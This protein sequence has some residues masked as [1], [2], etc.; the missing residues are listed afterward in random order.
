MSKVTGINTSKIQRK[1]PEWAK[2]DRVINGL[3]IYNMN[4][5]DNIMTFNQDNLDGEAIHYYGTSITYGE[6]PGLRDAYARGLAMAGVKEGDVVT[7]CMPVSI[8]NTMLLFAVNLLNAVSNNVNFLYLKH[9]FKTYTTDKNSHIVVTLD[10]F[11]PYFVDHLEEST[12]DTVIVMNLDDFLPEK[13]KGLFMDTSEM[14]KKMQE[15]FDIN[16]IMACLMNLDKIKGVNFIKLDELRKA[17]AESDIPLPYGPTN[18]DRDIS[19]YYTSGTTGKP[20]CVVY[21]EY[22]L[23]AYVEMHAGLDTQNVVGE[24]NFQ[25][26]PLTHMTGERVCTIMP[27]ARGGIL[28]PQPI[29]NNK[30]FARDLAASKCNCVVATAS[31][32]MKA[33]K[34]GVLGPDALKNLTRPGSGGEPITKSAVEKVDKWLRANGCNVRYSLG[35]GASEEGGATLVTYFMDEKTKTNETGLPLEPHVHVKLVDDEGNLI[36]EDEVLG[37]LHV[38]SPAAA[39][40]YLDNPEATAERWYVDEDGVKWGV[41]GDI[42]VRHADGSYNIL[43]R[44]SDSYINEKGERVYLFQIEYSLDREDPILEWEISAF[45]NECGGY[46]VVG[47]IILD[48]NCKTP[49]NELVDYFCKKYNLAAVKFY[50]EFELGEIT[51]KRDFVLLAHDYKGYVS[52]CDENHHY[53]VNYSEDGK[54]VRQKVAIIHYQY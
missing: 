9:D 24:R 15:V 10:A 14:P 51:N 8:E 21:K 19:Y 31:F 45:K 40:R 1:F 46:D 23:N 29:Y 18:L 36:T 37:N 20:K 6:L 33:V 44:A 28:V 2:V 7:L 27:L 3:E 39:D 43:G 54:T 22:S 53:L 52:P 4:I 48:P 50:Q 26:I 25:C 16:Q 32:Y 38:T 41:T 47:Q 13:R 5:F 17:G 11:L 42:A 34:Q 49:K 30:T 12:V 35:G